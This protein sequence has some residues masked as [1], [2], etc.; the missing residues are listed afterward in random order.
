MHS[1]ARPEPL[2]AWTLVVVD[3]AGR[4]IMKVA[5]GEYGVVP[6]RLAE[7]RNMRRDA[8]LLDQLVQHRA[9]P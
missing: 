7:H 4:V 3:I 8:L 9:D 6:L 2:S 1:T 5:A